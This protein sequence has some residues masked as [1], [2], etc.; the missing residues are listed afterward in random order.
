MPRSGIRAVAHGA[1][2]GIDFRDKTS[3]EAAAEPQILPPLR[4]WDVHAHAHPA[5]ARRA[6]F[7]RRFAAWIVRFQNFPVSQVMLT[8]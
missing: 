3:R 4:G 8:P 2:P 1:S 7:S 6:I 5:L